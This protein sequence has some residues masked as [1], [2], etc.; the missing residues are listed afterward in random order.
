MGFGSCRGIGIGIAF[1]VVVAFHG[2]VDAAEGFVD[3][4]LL[5]AFR[6]GGRAVERRVLRPV[7]DCD[8]DLEAANQIALQRL[9]T[10]KMSGTS[11]VL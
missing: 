11:S 4:G 6:R 2:A 9:L 10:C 8:V 5:L 7:R 3:F 1:A